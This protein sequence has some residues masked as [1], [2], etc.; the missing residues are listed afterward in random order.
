MNRQL[1]GGRPDWSGCTT[2]EGLKRAAAS[3]A[4]SWVNHAPTRLRRS[5]DRSAASGIRCAICC[6]VRHQHARQVTVARRVAVTDLFQG[7]SDLVVG[8]REDP[9]QHP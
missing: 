1:P 6:V 8:Q 9:R 5:S 3:T 2:A 4:N 7:R